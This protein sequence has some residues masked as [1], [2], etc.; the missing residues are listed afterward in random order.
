MRCISPITFR[1]GTAIN[2]VPCGKCNFCLQNR[3]NDWSFRIEQEVRQSE[4]AFFLTL[5]Y[6]E[7]HQP[8][9]D[10]PQGRFGTL[11]KKDFQDFMKRIRK[12]QETANKYATSTGQP[13]L[14]PIKY[15]AV[16]EYGT[17][18]YRP[19]Y[20]AIITNVQPSVIARAP[21][22]W[23]LGHVSVGTAEAASIHYTTKYVI[24]PTGKDIWEPL[25]PPFALISQGL[26][27]TY[28]DT[29]G[30][31]H[32]EA[33]ENFVVTDRGKQRLP[34]YYTD[35]IFNIREKESL[36]RSSI[37]QNDILHREAIE[38]LLKRE[39]DPALALDKIVQDKHALVE[40]TIKDKAINTGNQSI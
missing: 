18:T 6:D 23:G 36:T 21:Q 11:K 39:A 8:T 34:R 5:T 38:Q 35:K 2:T 7:E 28:L 25:L 37:E 10:L 3:R 26:G 9:V 16:G 1:Q 22:I 40:K 32:K 31:R 19:H 13:E 24:Q 15:Y 17:N 14:P 27:K 20:H 33:Q 30:F 12:A 4:T 29:N